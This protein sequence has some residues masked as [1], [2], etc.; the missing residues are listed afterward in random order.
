M[1]K[2]VGYKIITER[3]GGV[4][5]EDKVGV[6]IKEGLQPYGDLFITHCAGKEVYNQVMVKY[7]EEDGESS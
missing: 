1:R 7:E 2:I 3:I 5:L 4:P 6:L